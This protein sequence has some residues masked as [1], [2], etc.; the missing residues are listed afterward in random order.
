[1]HFSGLFQLPSPFTLNGLAR[2][3]CYAKV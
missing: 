1:M 3:N 2:S